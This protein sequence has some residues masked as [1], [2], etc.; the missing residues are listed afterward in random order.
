M[1]RRLT[2]VKEYKE[3]PDGP[4]LDP[5]NAAV[6]SGSAASL[7]AS[8]DCRRVISNAVDVLHTSAMTS[9]LDMREITR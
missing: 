8:S 9:E 5:L 6:R 3:H 7:L 2:Q 1:N 4:I